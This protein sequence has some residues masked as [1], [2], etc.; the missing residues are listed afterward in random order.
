MLNVLLIVF[1]ITLFYIGIANRLK[2]YI[3]ALA[4]QGFLLFGIAIF[5]LIEIDPYILGFILLETVVVKAIALPW[6]LNR[7]IKRNRITREAEPFLP[8]FVSLLIITLA[9]VLAFVLSKNITGFIDNRFFFIASITTLFTGVYISV[10]RKKIITQVMGYMVIENGV[11]LFS[12]AVGTEM[13]MLVNAGILLDVFASV[14]LLGIF[15]NKIG[16]L[17]KQD[18]SESLSSLKD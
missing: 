9:L 14:F 17:I 16:D 1:V 11:F 10:S 8:N 3:K 13:P 5:K 18:E 15:V 12:L 7:I 4:F 6:F 2:S